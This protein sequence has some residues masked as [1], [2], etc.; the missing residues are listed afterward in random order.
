MERKLSWDNPTTYVDGNP[1]APEKVS[2]IK[3]HVFKDGSEVYVTL[4][5]VTEWPIETGAPGAVSSWELS[6]ELDGQ[7]SARSPAFSFT[8]P[9][10]QP[11]PPRILAIS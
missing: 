4:P 3:I 6:A 7:V 8:E 9:F 10:L 5:G 1:I 11:M 2:G